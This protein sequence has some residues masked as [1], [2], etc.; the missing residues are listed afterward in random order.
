MKGSDV[1]AINEASQIVGSYH[2][3]SGGSHAHLWH[4]GKLS[5]LATIVPGVLLSEA[6]AISD[7][8]SIVAKSDDDKEVRL[9]LLK[10]RAS[11]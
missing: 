4:D 10:P 1:R 5:D 3:G 8:G 6:L 9:Y 2:P 11:G 7:R